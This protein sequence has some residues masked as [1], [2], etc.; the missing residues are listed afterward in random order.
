MEEPSRRRGQAWEECGRRRDE[1]DRG[2][3][4]LPATI[5]AP[6]GQ[7]WMRVCDRHPSGDAPRGRARASPSVCSVDDAARRRSLAGARAATATYP[8]RCRI[9]IGH[10]RARNGEDEPVRS[11]EE[12]GVFCRRREVR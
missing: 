11:V 12:T 2:R 4:Q 10:L 6:A 1:R 9:A 8:L 5:E 7:V 3:M